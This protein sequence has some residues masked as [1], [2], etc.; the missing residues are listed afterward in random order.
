[1][2]DAW[3]FTSENG[4]IGWDDY[5]TDYVGR[6]SVCKDP[7]NGAKQRFKNKTSHEEDK[8]TN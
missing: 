8:I 5:P 3:D 7:G 4:I 1:M 2:A 6:K